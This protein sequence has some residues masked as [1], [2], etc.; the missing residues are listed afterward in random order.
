MTRLLA[1]AI[2]LAAMAAP[3]NAAW[4]CGGWWWCTMCYPELLQQRQPAAVVR[5]VTPTIAS[6]PQAAVE[7]M[8]AQLDLI[9]GDVLYDLGCGDGRVLITAVQTYGCKAVGIEIDPAVAEY[10]RQRVR[11]AGCGRITIVTGDARRYDLTQAT[12]VT[13]YLMPPLMVE[14]MPKLR[15]TRVA[16][17][18]HPIPDTQYRQILIDRVTSVYVLEVDQ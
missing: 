5:Q 6:T 1:V 10:A 17:F 8:L 16:T 2:L 3:V 15:T 9:P 13:M 18:A 12:A 11:E 7:V 4:K 14:L